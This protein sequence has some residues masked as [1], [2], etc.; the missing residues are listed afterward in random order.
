[1]TGWR[2]GLGPWTPVREGDR[3][4]GRGGADDGYATFASLTAL[5]VL[6]EQGAPHARCVILIEGCEESGSS[7]LPYYLE[8]LADRIG[9]P[10]AGR[11][12]RLRRR[13]LRPALGDD[14]AARHRRRQPSR[15]DAEA[16]HP[17]RLRLRR[18]AVE[19]PRRCASSSTASRTRRRARSC[20]PSSTSRSRRSGSTRPNSWRASSATSV[21]RELPLLEGVEPAT[22]DVKELILNRTWRPALSVTGAAGLPALENA[23]NVLRASHIA[24]ALDPHPADLRPG[25]GDGGAQ[26]ASSRPT[27]PTAPTS[28][29]SPTTP[30]RAGTRRRP[31]PGCCDSI[32]RGVAGLLRPATPP[33][34]ARA[35]PSPSWRCWARSS[36]RRSS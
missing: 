17:L 19:L 32:E 8:A 34:W 24:E 7:D 10:V 33:S 16:G 1:M 23:G 2:E 28:A 31:S 13:Q 25:R 18:R 6:K 35:A 30:P 20:C 29:S 27:R 36:R 12:P 15:R 5:R 26:A 9:S 14:L 21:Y 22:R 3:L 4:Y 11:L